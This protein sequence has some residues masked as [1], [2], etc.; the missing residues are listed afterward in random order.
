MLSTSCKNC[1]DAFEAVGQLGRDGVEVDAAALLEVGELGDF[2]AIEHDLPADAPCAEG[3]RLPVIFFELDVVLAQ[4][5]ADGFERGEVKLLHVG[6][7]RLE[8]DLVLHVL[9]EAVGVLAVAAV[10]G[11]A[12]GLNVA[13]AIG[14]G[15]E[16]AEKGFGRHGSGADFDIV[17]LLED[18]TMIGPKSLQAKDE[19]LKGQRILRGGQ[20]SV[21]VCSFEVR[22]I[23]RIPSGAK[24]RGLEVRNG[25]AQ[26]VPLQISSAD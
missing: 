12:R 14:L 13:D 5:D 11:T 17:G 25:T 9:E 15:T 1:G 3:R 6:R 2:E 22:L 7:R 23:S 26:A 21:L 8:D 20:V 24:A 16:D 4:V 18:A 10:G 19:F